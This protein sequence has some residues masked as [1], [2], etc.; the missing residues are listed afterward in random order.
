MHV[1]AVLDVVGPLH[2]FVHVAAV[3]VELMCQT[4]GMFYPGQVS[5]IELERGR[6]HWLSD[7]WSTHTQTFCLWFGFVGVSWELQIILQS[8]SSQILTIWDIAFLQGAMNDVIS[9]P[10]QQHQRTFH[11]Y[12]SQH[13]TSCNILPFFAK[14][15]SVT[16]YLILHWEIVQNIT[17]FC[18]CLVLHCHELIL[19]PI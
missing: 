8:N 19:H 7:L 15:N 17:F 3:L 2:P 11:L 14:G 5:A 12:G 6:I 13:Q 10:T 4:G 1:Y 18:T 16:Y 9:I